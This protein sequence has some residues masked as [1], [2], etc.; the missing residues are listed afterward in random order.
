MRGGLVVAISALVLISTSARADENEIKVHVDGDQRLVVERRLADSELWESVCRGACDASLP[1]DG[2][3]RVTGHGIRPSLPLALLYDPRG[4]RANLA[5]KSRYESG[6]YGALVLTIL[7][8]SVMVG[9]TFA[10]IAGATQNNTNEVPPC[11]FDV[12]CPNEPPPS[13][14]LLVGGVGGLI[15]GALMTTAGI[16][17]LVLTDHSTVH[18]LGAFTL[19]PRGM[20]IRF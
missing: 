4:G 2:T 8:P 12:S 7:G 16:L 11:P 1:R 13:H 19:S 18:Q 9:G 15:T 14:G 3:Y 6:W 5:V 10:T 17:G 20:M